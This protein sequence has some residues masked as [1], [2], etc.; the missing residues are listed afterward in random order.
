MLVILPYTLLTVVPAPFCRAQDSSHTVHEILAL[1]ADQQDLWNNGS[2]RGYMEGYWKS[3]SL[4]F[5]S[6]G[7]IQQGYTATLE[8]YLR[9][10]PTRKEMG[11][12]FFSDLEVFPLSQNSAWAFGHWSLARENDRPHGVFTLIL[13]RFP[14]GWKIIHDHS[15]SE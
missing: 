4:L 12:L 13:R 9:K 15:S 2:I 14:D 11:T 10:Y 1:L 8:K 7:K 5:T 3:D 6:G